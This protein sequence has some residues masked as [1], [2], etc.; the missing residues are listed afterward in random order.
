[1][2]CFVIVLAGNIENDF[3]G[4]M[5]NELLFYVLLVLLEI[6]FVSNSRNLIISISTEN[7]TIIFS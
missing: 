1:M 7:Q 6:Y 3:D 4:F 5:E 2:N